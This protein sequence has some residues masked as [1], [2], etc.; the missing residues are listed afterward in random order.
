VGIFNF[1]KSA[2]E[3]QTPE[4]PEGFDLSALTDE[5]AAASVAIL[6]N[7]RHRRRRPR[8]TRSTRIH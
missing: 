4:E 2:K 5:P 8:T 7:H 3:P 6:R 1:K